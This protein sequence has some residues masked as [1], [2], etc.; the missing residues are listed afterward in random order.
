MRVLVGA[1]PEVFMFKNGQPV[2]AFGAIQGTKDKPF[3]V[4]KGAVQV[5]GMALE[6]NIDPAESAEEFRGHIRMVMAQ[7]QGMVPGYDLNP[8]PVANFGFDYISTQPKEATELGCNP[9]FNAWFDGEPNPKPNGELPFRTG[10]GHV[11]IG[12]TNKADV[13]DPEHRQACIMV[14]KQM[15]YYLGLG[16]LLYDNDNQRR[17]MYGSA[18]SF[19]YKPYGCEYRVLSNAWLKDDNLIQ[20]V[21]DR[22]VQGVND[23]AEGKAAFNEYGAL[24]QDVIRNNDIKEAKAIM[25]SLNIPL[26]MAA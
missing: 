18:G 11:H 20:W 4:D 5:D 3:K 25:H 19:R 22:T 14:T 6:F 1:D 23:L 15:D 12:W 24:A 21:F 13:Y 10:A 9:D 17:E 8:V 26:P 16:S 2:S 7:L